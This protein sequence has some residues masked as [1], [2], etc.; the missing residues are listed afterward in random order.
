MERVAKPA[1]ELAE[2]EA[3]PPDDPLIELLLGRS[4]I[5]GIPRYYS[6]AARVL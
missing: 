6:V 1:K 2:T 4:V 5:G 3:K